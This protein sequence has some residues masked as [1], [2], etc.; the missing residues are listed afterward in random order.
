MNRWDERYNVDDYVY[1]TAPNDF[2]VAV[3]PQIPPGNVLC[4]AEG[5]GRNAVFLAAQGYA[6]VAVDYSQ[7]GLEKAQRLAAQRG[8]TIETHCTD[9]QTFE[10]APHRWSAIVSI[11]VHQPV[12][13]RSRLHQQVVQGLLPGGVFVLEAYTPEQLQ[14][15]TGGPPTPELMANLATL[16]GELAGLEWAIAQ[17]CIRDIQEGTLHHGPGAVVQL[18][19]RK[20][21]LSTGT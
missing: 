21:I 4:L 7:I 11:F 16:Q 17:E 10:I 1:G 6:V 12:A 18:L 19:G 3:G 5:E 8:V 15:K 20:P 2:L 14:Y 13:V 9:L